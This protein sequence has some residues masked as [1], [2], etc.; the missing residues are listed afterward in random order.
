VLL[1]AY[2]ALKLPALG[3]EIATIAG[4]YPEHRN[5]VLRL[6]EL[7]TA[8]EEE[9]PLSSEGREEERSRAGGVELVFESASVRS[10][11]HWI[12][13]D[14]D[15]RIEAGSQVAV[16]GRSGAGKS[17]LLGLILGWHRPATGQV[18]VDGQPLDR[19]RV[20]RL[21]RETAWVD[22]AVQIW[23]RT[24]LDNVLY[25][26]QNGSLGDTIAAVVEKAELRPLLQVLPDGHQTKLGESGALVSGGEGQRVR[27][28]RAFA[29][30]HPRLAVLDEPFR[31]LDRSQRSALLASARRIWAGATLLCVTHDIQETRSFDRV[32]VV[33]GGRVVEDGHPAQLE[34]REGSRYRAMLAEERA[35]RKLW[36][37]HGWRRLRLLSGKFLGREVAS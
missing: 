5:V 34:S 30:R 23:N 1:L 15:L 21:R 16:V 29:R 9:G 33:E 14:V 31:G 26:N 17:T 20:A 36:A 3:T 22:P 28:A 37:S 32:V 10:G 11:G 7:L 13:R 18:R 19:A 24:L 4:Q 8:P 35:A 2:W 6:L 27:L 25:G 12:L